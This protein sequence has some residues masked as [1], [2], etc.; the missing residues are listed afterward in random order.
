[1]EPGRRAGGSISSPRGGL[2]RGVGRVAMVGPRLSVRQLVLVT[3][4]RSTSG[5]VGRGSPSPGSAVTLST[6]N[7]AG[8]T[9]A[10]N[11][12]CERPSSS[13]WNVPAEIRFRSSGP[14][15]GA[16]EPELVVV[17]LREDR[18][19]LAAERDH[20][21]DPGL[22]NVD[23]G[24]RRPTR[25]AR[26][27]QPAAPA[28]PA[29]TRCR[30][31]ARAPPRP[32]PRRH[33]RRRRR[34]AIARSDAAGGQASRSSSRA[35]RLRTSSRPALRAVWRT[36]RRRRGARAVSRSSVSSERHS[37]QLAR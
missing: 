31:R 14:I 17:A 37:P 16:D 6:G 20:A 18:Q 5:P 23:G 26:T 24:R 30:P 29:A 2:P 33:L 19:R 3:P 1:M 21:T 28:L 8:S 32:R 11:R 36:A 4:E 27:A 13:G 7:V 12:T 10:A 25:S 9:A 35:R 34:L 22:T 15:A